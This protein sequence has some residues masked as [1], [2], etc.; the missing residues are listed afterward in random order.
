MARPRF[1]V[2]KLTN[3]KHLFSESTSVYKLLSGY[4]NKNIDY[5]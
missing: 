4:T 3:A 2:S 5:Y 1:K